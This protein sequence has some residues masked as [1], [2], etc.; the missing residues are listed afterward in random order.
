MVIEAIIFDCF[1]VLITP[2]RTI[3]HQDYPQFDK[4]IYNL[5]YQSDYGIISQQEFNK[6]IAEIT[7]LT[8]REVESRYWDINVHNEPIF[9]WIRE[10]KL[11]GKYRIG[12]LSNVGHG[13]LKDLLPET[14]RKDLFDTVI[15][16]SDVGIIKPDTRIFELMANRLGVLPYECVMID[17]TPSNIDG[18]RHADMQGIVFK[19]IHQAQAEFKRLLESSNA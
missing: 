18:A 10:L 7:G 5:D 6:S 4:E 15:L 19:S 3:L 9:A 12:L 16:S 11:S 14:E 8:P 13:W 17:D 2:G 1:G